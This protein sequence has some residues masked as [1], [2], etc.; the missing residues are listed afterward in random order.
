MEKTKIIGKYYLEW[1]LIL[2]VIVYVF[3]SW[4]Q[5]VQ[6]E[7]ESQP[8]VIDRNLNPSPDNTGGSGQ[9]GNSLEKYPPIKSNQNKTGTASGYAPEGVRQP[10]QQNSSTQIVPNLPGSHEQQGC[11]TSQGLVCIHGVVDGGGIC[12]K[13]INQSCS[14]RNECTP[15]SDGCIYGFC[16]AFGEVI[17]KPCSN[18]SECDG[19]GKFNHV[20]D[21]ISRR[22]KFNLFPYDSGCVLDQ[23]CA[24]FTTADTPNQVRCLNNTPLVEYESTYDGDKDFTI[25][26]T[27][28]LEKDYYITLNS[29]EE[30]FL[31]R[32]LITNVSISG[33]NSVVTLQN[34]PTDL[35]AGNS[36]TIDLGGQ[37]DGICL[38]NFPLGAKR[39]PVVDVNP[40]I[41]YPC[42]TNLDT[43]NN[44]CVEKG[45]TSTKGSLGQV[46]NNSGLGC[47][48][49][50][51]CT[52]DESFNATLLA[53]KNV[54]GTGSGASI[55]GI[56]VISIGKCA[57]QVS[58]SR[59]IC[60][61]AEKACQPP[62]ICLNQ[63]T[64]DGKNFRYCGREWDVF[65]TSTLIGCPRNYTYQ[66]EN[67]ICLSNPG[68]ICLTSSD[69][70][71]TCNT[72]HRTI[73]SYD[74]DSSSFQEVD[75]SK[76]S[77]DGQKI[78]V[79]KSFGTCQ[80]V[81][82]TLGTYFFTNN[83]LTIDLYFNGTSQKTTKVITFEDTSITNPQVTVIQK[84]DDS[85]Q[86]NI[87]YKDTYK[88]YT[89]R[90]YYFETTGGIID[91]NFGLTQGSSI[92]FEA[93]DSGVTSPTGIYQLDYNN[94]SASGS[95]AVIN[96]LDL[97][98]GGTNFYPTVKNNPTKYKMVSYD[99]G[100]KFNKNLTTQ[101]LD[102]LSSNTNQQDRSYKYLN[103]FP[104]TSLTFNSNSNTTVSYFNDSTALSLVDQTTY[105]NVNVGTNQSNTTTLVLT[106]EISDVFSEPTIGGTS[107]NTVNTTITVSSEYDPDSGFI[108]LPE[109][110]GIN[111]FTINIPTTPSEGTE[112]I[113]INKRQEL[114]SPNT[115]F[116]SVQ[117]NYPIGFFIP[118]NSN[119]SI[120]VE[121]DNIMLTTTINNFAQQVT[122]LN[123]TITDT[124]D[125]DYN[126]S[127]GNKY[128]NTNY[129]S[130]G[131][132]SQF[133]NFQITNNFTPPNPKIYSVDKYSSIT[134]DIISF[135]IPFQ[136]DRVQ[137]YIYQTSDDNEINFISSYKNINPENSRTTKE[138]NKINIANETNL[139]KIKYNGFGANQFENI[140][141]LGSDLTPSP[142]TV[143]NESFNINPIFES[144]GYACPI[145]MNKFISSNTST[146]S[147]NN[148]FIP[149][150]PQLYIRN[151]TDIDTILKYSSSEIV[152]GFYTGRQ[153]SGGSQQNKRVP[154]RYVGITGIL[155]YEI[156]SI[157]NETLI[158]S[159]NTNLDLTLV[160]GKIPYLFV[161][162]IVPIIPKSVTPL[163]FEDG[164]LIVTSC[165]PNINVNTSNRNLDFATK[166]DYN[167]IFMTTG[168]NPQYQFYCI[169]HYQ[170]VTG[171]AP[172]NDIYFNDD[173]Y[174]VTSSNGR[175]F[176]GEN[177]VLYG[178][179]SI[180][181]GISYLV[182]NLFLS[183]LSLQKSLIINT[184]TR[185][186]TDR[187][188][189]KSPT[190]R[191]GT[192]FL[193]ND[194]IPFYNGFQQNQGSL[195]LSYKTPLYWS[196]WIDELNKIPIEI[197]KIIYNF[198]PG[199]IENDMFYYALAKINGDPY[200]VFLSTNFTLNNIAESQ[201]VPVKLPDT[202][203]QTITDR[204][205]MTP[206]DRKLYY[207]SSSCN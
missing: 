168:I 38:I 53:N 198:N 4:R 91:S 26:G 199:N 137:N 28:I 76:T 136:L 18:T 140:E 57:N 201:P 97:V 48:P 151:Q 169:R 139:R 43:L 182:N 124:F 181:P 172:F 51:E 126:Y 153:N 183:S 8:I 195:D 29:Q 158:L 133:I 13:N 142:S 190:N 34:L 50:L 115:D 54:I 119:Y 79:S 117:Y 164:S 197:I 64:N 138:Y 71:K 35:D 191:K 163:T 148:F 112:N 203:T 103:L 5:I 74:L 67:N 192:Y 63:V 95:N 171:T 130:Y 144:Y 145:E 160:S 205:F 45:R 161:N 3:A 132:S 134:N 37:E 200:F 66:S 90:E 88:N 189:W 46:C 16:Q 12:L 25:S 185:Q 207:L 127:S 92:Y 114:Y 56:F 173:S 55:G 87:I 80:T 174:Q 75:Y 206:F 89:R 93:I 49:G 84:S 31:G 175:K 125:T 27:T 102:F 113:T 7:I 19:G 141:Y 123:Y 178:P 121:E 83:Q 21:P 204:M 104:G 36:Y 15:L 150:D 11:D 96:S 20:C 62:N 1:I 17:N 44:F 157:F 167:K 170:N 166:T 39:T 156:D 85:H 186:I 60:N 40:N 77:V 193:Y 159:T 14:A 70:L 122:K 120:E 105:Y 6:E 101:Q 179:I 143:D 155:N 147:P 118:K 81:P 42:E 78:V 165:L 180:N 176:P 128:K 99:S 194:T 131:T 162:N 9:N 24:L 202:I 52:F 154:D 106:D 72:S 82:S 111:L 129:V 146:T 86:L 2:I 107:I 33:S 30:G 59:E 94:V 98:S 108:Q 116:S 188:L 10:C 22:C 69:C 68:N 177:F 23:Q 152:I 109:M 61:D 100:F 187:V 184:V 73:N 58:I 65:E 32:F 110:E 149:G 47:N 41:L 135:D 196:Y